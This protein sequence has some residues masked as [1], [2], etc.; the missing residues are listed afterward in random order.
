MEHK[1][2]ESYASFKLQNKVQKWILK[3]GNIFNKI[4]IIETWISENKY[5]SFFG[6][7]NC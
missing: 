4:T 1:I 2:L 7:K 5:A 3:N 6:L